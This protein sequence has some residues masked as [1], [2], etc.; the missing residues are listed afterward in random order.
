MRRARNRRG[1]ARRRTN[2]VGIK[3]K[4]V[5]FL[6]VLCFRGS[7]SGAVAVGHSPCVRH[8]RSWNDAHRAVLSFE[9][10]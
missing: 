10:L 5:L 8:G 2:K 7:D 4:D 9:N 6:V 1:K 3:E